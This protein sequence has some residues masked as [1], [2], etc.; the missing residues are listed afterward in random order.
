MQHL[1]VWWQPLTALTGRPPFKLLLPYLSQTLRLSSAD[2]DNPLKASIFYNVFNSFDYS[3]WSQF[4]AHTATCS[5]RLPFLPR[6]RARE[7]VKRANGGY[8]MLTVFVLFINFQIPNLS[9]DC[10]VLMLVSK[11]SHPLSP[12]LSLLIDMFPVY[13]ADWFYHMHFQNETR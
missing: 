2:S 7:T 8:K 12:I 13:L 6:F 5:R 4:T 3:R 11:I 10:L 9:N 1:A